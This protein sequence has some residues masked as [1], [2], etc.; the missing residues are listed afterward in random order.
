MTAFQLESAPD[1]SAS[2]FIV[3]EFFNNIL[4]TGFRLFINVSDPTTGD[5]ISDL[6]PGNFV[7]K[8][9]I[10]QQARGFPIP[11]PPF[12]GTP[13]GP[14][15]PLDLDVETVNLGDGLYTSKSLNRKQRAASSMV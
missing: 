15:F 1:P 7:V 8:Q 10:S 5:H 11:V 2:S 13:P 14:F 9:P 3:D 4:S 6:G 12:V